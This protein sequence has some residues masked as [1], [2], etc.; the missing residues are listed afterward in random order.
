M[1]D[2]PGQ[3]SASCTKR[4]IPGAEALAPPPYTS[5]TPSHARQR[6]NS[7]SSHL[8]SSLRS[9]SRSHRHESG[10]RPK[11]PVKP[12]G[13]DT[14]DKL[15]VTGIYGTAFVHHDG[16]FDACNP[17]RNNKSSRAP[18]HA[19]AVGSSNN[20][21]TG[22]PPSKPNHDHLFGHSEDGWA[23]FDQEPKIVPQEID[24][25]TRVEPIHGVQTNGLGT[26]TFLEGTPASRNAIQQHEKEDA[27]RKIVKDD[28]GLTRKKSLAQRFRGMS[29]GRSPRPDFS[30]GRPTYAPGTSFDSALPA[31]RSG[32]VDGTPPPISSRNALADVDAAE[33]NR[34][35]GSFPADTGTSPEQ[36]RQGSA[37]PPGEQIGSKDSGGFL[38][39]VKSLKGG[40]K[41]V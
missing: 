5:R 29:Q 32:A 26:S 27:T 11:A 4:Q 12:K 40:R 24:P 36:L 7:E 14:I 25:L 18:L 2:N 39:R 15:D 37:R 1:A 17:H 41:R 3:A 10:R 38:S 6:R 19:F 8:D 9:K 28:N 34:V 13:Y 22:P 31:E 20:S 33:Y 16:P 30:D 23:M 35:A 21:L